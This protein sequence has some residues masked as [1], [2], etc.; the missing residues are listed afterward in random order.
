MEQRILRFLFLLGLIFVFGW[1]VYQTTTI[2]LY[3]LLSLVIALIGRPL[4]KL[5]DKIQIRK[6][7][8]PDAL[9]AALTLLTIFGILGGIISYFVPMIFKEAQLLTKID[10]DQV[11]STLKPVLAWYN[12]TVAR[13]NINPD[14]QVDESQLVR[15]LFD[16]LEFS[17]LPDYLNSLVGA[18][19][20]LMI[21]VFSIAFMSFFFLKDRELLTRVVLKLVPIN[22]EERFT[23]ILS[24][25]RNTLSR[26]FLGLFVQVLAI[27]VC[28]Y[29]GL[30]IV[31]V[32]NALLI[33]AFTGIVNLIPYLGP[34][35]G[36]TFGLFIIVSNNLDV[37]FTEVLQP[38]LIGLLIVFGATQMID[39][40]VFQP[41]I[42]SSSINAHPLEIFIVILVAGS[43]GG[44]TGMI[45]AIPIY[46]FIRIVFIEMNKEFRWLERIKEK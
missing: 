7:N 4:F 8:L 36:A 43:L 13:L 20:N 46:S 6:R 26:Y 25:T 14:S 31:G 17:A 10:L 32:E 30:S 16:S 5:L 2:I 24:N 38:Q 34:W 37:S 40:Y 23:N 29:I 42:F 19:G 22:R 35:I 41:T 18:L 33:A 3:L 9:K 27:T 28:I 12:D 11:R 21:A 39:N 1:V 45:A 15:Y 44:V